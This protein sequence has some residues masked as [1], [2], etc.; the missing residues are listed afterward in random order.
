[1][2]CIPY[3]FVFISLLFCLTA[4]QER[5]CKFNIGTNLAG[6]VDYGSEWPLVDIMKYC[7]EWITHNSAWVEEGENPWDTGYINE[8]PAD[9]NGYP[10]QLPCTIA[11]AET[12]QAVRG[13]WANTSA[14]KAGNYT[15]LYD[16]EGVLDFWGDVSVI[17]ESP[18]RIVVNVNPQQGG[19]IMTLSIL[20]ST[21]GN[22]IRNIRFLMPGTE[23]S[24][25]ENKWCQEWLDKLEPFKTLRFMDWFIT[26]NSPLKKWEDRVQLDDYTYTINGM[27]YELAIEISNKRMSDAWICVPHLADSGYIRKMAELF[28][29]NLNPNLKIYVEYSNEIW[30]W[31]F[32]QTHYCYEN[33][34]AELEWPE[35]I[36][37]FIQNCMDI[38]TDV[39]EGQLDRI[40]RVV[41]V[42]HAWQDVS[43]RIVFNMR[44]GSFDAF[45]PAA[46]FG[47]PEDSLQSAGAETTAQDILRL[48]KHSMLNESYEWTK[49]Q[50]ENIA[51]VLGIPMLYYEGGQHLTPYPFGS[52]Q[53]YNQALMDA[54]TDPGM[55]NLYT[56][57]FDSLKSVAGDSESLFMNFSFIS[58]KSGKYGSWGVLES[59]FYQFPPYNQ[60]APKFQAILDNMCKT[61]HLSENKELLTDYY[62]SQNYPNP[63]NPSTMINYQL[64]INSE[65]SLKIYDILGREVATLVN[66]QKSPGKYGVKFDGSHLSSGIY[67][68]RMIA[69]DYFSAK[70]IMLLK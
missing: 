16:G 5:Y 35:R 25:Q 54:Q 36:V 47:L 22:H 39:F 51:D 27:P 18:G 28:R 32:D 31:M 59:Q 21:F 60:S 63:F 52:E 68:C 70:K 1:M 23:E 45:S 66:G 20:Q 50:K 40:V 34:P 56:E 2:K 62:L 26:N 64:P 57:W 12:T 46:Y 3:L 7:R 37:P 29:D 8:I 15:V 6:P 58:P 65:V 38:W 69:G 43:N 53:P 55:Y 11:G 33:G 41:G 44:S 42:Q 13:I 4:A 67:I 30:N 10:L 9:S 61:A 49:S 19:N 24:Y 14:L 48:A 17:S